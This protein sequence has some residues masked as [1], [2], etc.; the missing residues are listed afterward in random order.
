VAAER[1]VVDQIRGTRAMFGIDAGGIEH[2]GGFKLK[3]LGTKTLK[4]LD[5][6]LRQRLV[7]ILH[8]GLLR[9]RRAVAYARFI[10]GM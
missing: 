10:T 1:D 5:K 7:S 2:A 4:M 3:H 6:L 8:F 9:E